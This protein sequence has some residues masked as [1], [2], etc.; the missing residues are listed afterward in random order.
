M[1]EGRS[2]S[3]P[4]VLRPLLYSISESLGQWYATIWP[5][6][7]KIWT[8]PFQITTQNPE[9]HEVYSLYYNKQTYQSAVSDQCCKFLSPGRPRLPVLGQ[10][11]LLL[12]AGSPGGRPENAIEFYSGQDTHTSRQTWTDGNP[13]SGDGSQNLCQTI[14][15]LTLSCPVV[16]Q[17]QDVSSGS[18]PG[19]Y[20]F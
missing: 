19:D 11:Y 15:K 6:P 1:I 13:S 14:K 3:C 17:F 16:C 4:Y 10:G 7:F 20:P 9:Q 12:K 18:F 8:G 2:L 5:G